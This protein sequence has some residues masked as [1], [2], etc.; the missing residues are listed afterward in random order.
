MKH[1]LREPLADEQE[2]LDSIAWVGPGIEVHNYR[3]WFDPPSSQEL[4]ASNGIHAALVVGEQRINPM[5]FDLDIEG[6]GILRNDDLA[7][8]GIVAEIMTGPLRS[9]QWLIRNLIQRGEHLS[10]GDFVIPGSPVGPVPVERNDRITATF[11]HL[12]RVTAE[13]P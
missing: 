7:E 9:L 3:F 13:F 12:G 10:T 5:T 2:I 11:K 6:V 4:V 8:T 1:D